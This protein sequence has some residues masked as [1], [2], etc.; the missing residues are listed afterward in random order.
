MITLYLCPMN[1]LL[2]ILGPTASGKTDLAAHIAKELDGEIISADSRQVYRGLNI[3]AGKDLE[4]YTVGGTKIP[5]HLIDIC[6]LNEEYNVFRFQQ[7]FHETYQQIQNQGKQAVLCGGTGLY[8]QTILEGHKLYPASIDP[9]L[10]QRLEAKT[11][12]EL[13][14]ILKRYADKPHNTTDTKIRTRTIR[15]IEI[16]KSCI[17]NQA[18]TKTF[19]PV[20]AKVFGNAIKREVLKQRITLRLKDRLKKGMIEEVEG[21]LESGIAKDRLKLLGLEY[22]FLVQY[23]NNE[24]SYQEMFDRLNIAIHQYSRRQMAWFRRMEKHGHEI[25]WIDGEMGMHKKIEAIKQGF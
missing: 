5:H 20:R 14:D 3:G 23:L 18:G 6:G 9:D 13:A 24:M 19:P 1:K 17:E 12:E 21:L 22:K 4:K 8:L 7:D 16:A 11:Q 25:H 10:R 15:A 2:T